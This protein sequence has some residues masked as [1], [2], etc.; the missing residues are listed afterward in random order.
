M[1]TDIAPAGDDRPAVAAGQAAG[2]ARAA[3]PPPRRPRR[4]DRRA[5]PQ[6]LRRRGPRAPRR[7][8]RRQHLRHRHRPRQPGDGAPARRAGRPRPQPAAR[9]RAMRAA[10]PVDRRT[11]VPRP[12]IGHGD[13]RRRR[14]RSGA[15]RGVTIRTGHRRDLA[16]G[17]RRRLARR[18]RARSTPSCWRRR[19]RPPRRCSPAPRPEAAR[20]LATMEHAGVVIVTLAVADWPD[21][22]RGRSGYLVP[23]PVQR[24]VTAASFG[25]QKWAHWRPTA[26]RG[27]ARLARSRR[28]ARRPPRRRRARRPRRRR[29][30]RPPRPRPPADARC[31]CRAGPAAFPQYRPHHRDWHAAVDAA[32]PA[33]VVVT[34]ASYGGIGVPAC[35]AQAERDRRS[36]GC[37]CCTPDGRHAGRL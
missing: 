8:P 23:K 35:I 29:G 30:R 15:G 19:R 32:L 12:A 37:C 36:R 34:G 22:L 14:R 17:R 26:R 10:T 5:R 7:R 20:L 11:A 9:R 28:P 4:L 33:G 27:A 1:P 6:P 25:S 31:A 21:R 3:A 16:R 13:A 24:T 18:R 2:G